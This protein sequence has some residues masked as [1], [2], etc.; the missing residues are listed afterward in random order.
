MHISS[1]PGKS[2]IGTLGKEAR[3]FADFLQ[4]AGQTCWQVLP[5]CPTG[6]GDSPYQSF[7]CEAGNPYF[8][9]LDE[10]ARQGLLDK[11]DYEAVPWGENP[12][13]VNY[14]I[15]YRER[16]KILRTAA[17]NFLAAP[18]EQYGAF[19]K[20]N[21][22]WIEDY[23]VFMT[24]KERNS[25]KPWYLW[26]A[27]LRNREKAA[28][29]PFCE[30]YRE[31]IAI[32]KAIQ[33]LFFCQ[34]NALKRYT[35]SKGILMIGDLPIYVALDST[36]VWAHRELFQLDET[37]MPTEVSG[38]PPDGFSSTGQLWGN[39][40]YNWDF[41]KQDGY[42]WWSRRI[43]YLCRMFDI[44]RIDHFRGFESYYAIPAGEKD[45]RNGVWRPGPGSALFQAIR[46]NIG[47]Q[48][49]IAENLGYLTP[50]VTKLLKE[51]G[52]PGMK[53]L[54]FCFDERDSDGD[55]TLPENFEEN[56]V[57]Y[58]GTHDNDTA[59][60]WLASARPEDAA[61][62]REHMQLKEEEGLVWGMLATLWSTKAKLTIATAQDLL[63][64]GSTAR[65]NTPSR[66]RGNWVW[67]A[68]PG[69]FTPE[70]AEKLRSLTETYDRL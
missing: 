64:L 33:Y 46:E 11:S 56:C 59:L 44:L 21:A 30:T 32:W 48:H 31:E 45:A 34:W 66:E 17:K 43:D 51:S 6:Y 41:M 10:L 22:S 54:Q 20:E 47:D 5:V 40:L 16:H 23:A 69:S 36:S 26:E 68:L 58:I 70:L 24:L 61:R 7:C 27:P 19:L 14:G 67:R 65:M 4:A 63:E 62:A 50:A 42:A 9:D 60:G 35:G 29:D 8:I 37:G 2:G 57:A 39:P 52:Y 13:E 12:S 15:L 38:C 53:L 49:I 18:D 3:D 55:R 25:G 1:L 28:L